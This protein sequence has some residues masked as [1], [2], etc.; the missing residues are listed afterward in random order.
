LDSFNK[1]LEALTNELPY[2]LPHCKEVDHRI[3]LVLNLALS[4]KA[5]YNLNK[6]EHE[7]LKK[8]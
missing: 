2:A 3:E 6:K 8:S 1:I 5:P 7:E 4:F